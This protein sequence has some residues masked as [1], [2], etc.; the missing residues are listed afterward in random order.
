MKFIKIDDDTI[1]LMDPTSVIEP[2]WMSVS[3]GGPKE[4]YEIELEPFNNH[5]RSVFAILWLMSEVMNGGLYQFYT[6]PTGIVWEDALKGF[7][8]LGITRAHAIMKESTK[9]FGTNPS[10]IRSERED[11]LDRNEEIEFDDL[12]TLFYQLDEEM[13]LTHIIAQYIDLNRAHFY[14]EGEIHI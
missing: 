1:D 13:N 8:L 4:R 9:R 14:F 2:L 5:Q 6:N 11:F 7:E 3:A 12:D 10:F